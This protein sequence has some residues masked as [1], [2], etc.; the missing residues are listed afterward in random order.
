MAVKL[1]RRAFEHAKELIDD[2]K[3]VFDERDAWMLARTKRGRNGAAPITAD[4]RR[5]AQRANQEAFR[6]KPS[7]R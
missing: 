2:G 4:Q 5:I 3:F 6:P 7:S 1:N